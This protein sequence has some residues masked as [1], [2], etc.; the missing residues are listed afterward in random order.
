MG[1]RK[2]E[3]EKRSSADEQQTRIS[4]FSSSEIEKELT[5]EKEKM[6]SRRI[7]RNVIFTLI[8]I[9]AGAV[10]IATLVLPIFR[11]YGTSMSPTLNKGDIV[12]AVKGTNEKQ[13]DLIAFYYNNKILVK[14]VIATEGEWVDI[15][16]NGNVFVNDRMLQEPYLTEKGLGNCD[17]NLPYQVPEGT[18]FVMGDH[19]N[20]SLDSRSSSVGC[21]SRDQIVGK[22][23]FRIWPFNKMG[24]LK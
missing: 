20:V 24:Q 15:D 23:L 3:E 22:L 6:R 19:R 16:E 18:V 4:S 10:L 9:A 14:R 8:T 2:N 13:G 5:Y 12:A 11:I 1:K 17:I 7:L 21:I